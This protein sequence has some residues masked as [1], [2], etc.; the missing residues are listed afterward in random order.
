MREIEIPIWI[1][2]GTRETA[3]LPEF[4]NSL[5]VAFIGFSRFH[6]LTN[7]NAI[8]SSLGLGE[9]PYIER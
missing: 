8:F 4:N 7:Y 9:N 1:V 6:R 5:L 3:A 2:P